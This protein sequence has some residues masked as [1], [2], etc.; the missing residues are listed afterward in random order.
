MSITGITSQDQRL[1][2]LQVLVVDDDRDAREALESSLQFLGACAVGVASAEEARRFLEHSRPDVLLS[3]LS[4]PEEDGYTFLTSVRRL[5]KERGG[6]VP[7]AAVSAI[8][9]PVD[10]RRAFAVGFQALIAKPFGLQEIAETVASL[11][12]PPIV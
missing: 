12:K 11:A 7:A 5:P 3:D 1:R 8:A 10:H 4:M 2:G 9:N 6:D